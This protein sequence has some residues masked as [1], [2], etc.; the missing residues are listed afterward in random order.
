MGAR[1]EFG[2]CRGRGEFGSGPNGLRPIAHGSAGSLYFDFKPEIRLRRTQNLAPGESR[3]DRQ[4]AQDGEKIALFEADLLP[5][6]P[7]N[8]RSYPEFLHPP[9][10]VINRIEPRLLQK[11]RTI[12]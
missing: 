4:P 11:L 10:W 7:F 12:A 8:E 1:R 9:I 3:V 2:D 5:E 6:T